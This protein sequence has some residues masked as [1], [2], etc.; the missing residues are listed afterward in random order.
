MKRLIQIIRLPELNPLPVM[1]CVFT[2]LCT[3]FE[4]D[5]SCIVSMITSMD[6]LRNGGIAFLDDAGGNYIHY[7]SIY[8]EIARRCPHT[9]FICWYCINI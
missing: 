4:E 6:Q 7:R 3:A 2:E 9:I 8:D 1:K 5:D